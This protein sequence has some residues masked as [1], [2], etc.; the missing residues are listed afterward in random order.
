MTG[1]A[2]LLSSAVG[3]TTSRLSGC[4]SSSIVIKLH[5]KRGTAWSAAAGM[6]CHHCISR[7]NS[8]LLHLGRSA[9][10]ELTT[11]SRPGP[12]RAALSAPA[13]PIVRSRRPICGGRGWDCS[14]T[15]ERARA[16]AW[17]ASG[18]LRMAGRRERQ[19][20]SPERACE[21][22]STDWRS[23]WSGSVMRCHVTY[24]GPQSA[25]VW[26]LVRPPPPPLRPGHPVPERRRSKP[27]RAIPVGSG[28][29]LGVTQ[30]VIVSATASA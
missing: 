2:S 6:P 12:G 10:G 7:R 16:H 21:G 1:R 9:S 17:V 23:R 8:G 30:P 4:E 11:A 29:D 20:P 13:L 18:V 22:H 19:R 5:G 28:R 14:G 3:L 15:N 24:C 25:C 26:A 27:K